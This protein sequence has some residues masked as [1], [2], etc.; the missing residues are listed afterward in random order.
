MVVFDDEVE[1][2]ILY[3]VIWLVVSELL[4]VVMV[5]VSD[6]VVIFVVVVE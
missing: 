5:D 4:L 3:C 1:I 2:V 6:L